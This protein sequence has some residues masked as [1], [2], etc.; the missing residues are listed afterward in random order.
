MGRKISTLEEIRVHVQ[1]T[2]PHAEVDLFHEESGPGATTRVVEILKDQLA[3]KKGRAQICWIQSERSVFPQALAQAEL[4]L[5]QITWIQQKDSLWALETALRSQIFGSI[6][7]EGVPLRKVD[8]KVRRRLR[9][10]A[11]QGGTSLLMLE[12]A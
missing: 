7:F 9:L 1:H 12:S 5:A 8:E 6:V 4:P 10:M 3:Q 11:K 2:A